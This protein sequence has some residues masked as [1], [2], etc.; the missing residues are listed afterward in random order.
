MSVVVCHC[1]T[2]VDTDFDDEALDIYGD[3]ECRSCRLSRM[4]FM[5][6]VIDERYERGLL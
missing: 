1:G 6:A 3:C 5:S 2:P 4:D